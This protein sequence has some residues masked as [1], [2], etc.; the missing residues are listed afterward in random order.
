MIVE[1]YKIPIEV[2][3]ITFPI[4]AF[5]FTLPFLIYEYHKYGAIPLIKSIVVYSFILYML[6]AYFM[7]ILPLPKI[8]DVLNYKGPTMQL[9]PFQFVNDIKAT[10][11]LTLNSIQ[12]I[13]TFLNKSTVYT[14][15]FNILLTLPFGI[16]LKYLFNKKWY[17]AIFASFLLSLFFELTQLSGLYGIYPRPYR[18]FDVDD[19]IINTAGGTI[20]YIISPL[21]LMF[22]PS[23]EELTNQSYKKGQK[24]SI[25]RRSVALF[26]DI[27]FLCIFSLLFKVIL[28]GTKI[29]NFYFI[30]AIIFY[31]IIVP[32]F[33]NT[34]TFGKT[35][36]KLEIVSQNVKLKLFLNT[37]RNILLTFLIIYPFAW[38]NL[39]EN[40]NYRKISVIAILLIQII[41]IISF[42]VPLNKK[43]LFLYER[44]TRTEN[45]SVIYFENQ[46]KKEDNLENEVNTNEEETSK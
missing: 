9:I 40:Q 25:I 21:F 16:Y 32:V 37:L 4:V 18:L 30:L 38:I 14:V 36:V 42:L 28:L 34:K 15:L 8:S 22:L 45:K 27:I 13:L 1:I 6:T 44:L 31:Y 11:T 33:N 19:L 39:I 43:H 17:Q 24:V 3:F 29:H 10:S 26:I 2:A 23:R 35:I 20:G 41:N 5:F 7:V 12:S 46:V